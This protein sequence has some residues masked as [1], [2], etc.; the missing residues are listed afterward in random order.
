MGKMK[1]KLEDFMSLVYRPISILLLSVV[2]YF[3]HGVLEQVKNG[4]K[5]IQEIKVEQ[6]KMWGEIKLL[7]RENNR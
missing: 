4:A 6:V 2:S 7:S 5:M 1:R 3:L